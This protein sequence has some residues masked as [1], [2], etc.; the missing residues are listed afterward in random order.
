MLTNEQGFLRMHERIISLADVSQQ[1][2]LLMVNSTSFNFMRASTQNVSPLM[3]SLLITVGNETNNTLDGTEINCTGVMGTT[4][5]TTSTT[6]R[7]I[8]NVSTGIDR[9]IY[10]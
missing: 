6:I 10:R 1:A 9:Q 4:R 3:S 8:E 5:I 2:S 7:V